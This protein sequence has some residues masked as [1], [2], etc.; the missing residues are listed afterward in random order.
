MEDRRNYERYEILLQCRVEVIGD[1]R[2]QV[3]SLRTKNI[4]S[5]GAFVLTESML[6]AGSL[7]KMSM[8]MRSQKIQEITGVQGLIE[9]D[10]HVV[11]TARDGIGIRFNNKCH[12][13]GLRLE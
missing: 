4:S 8:A 12:I 11:R 1:E 6:P 10:G 5:S 9:C 2:K 13:G 3:Y 7:V